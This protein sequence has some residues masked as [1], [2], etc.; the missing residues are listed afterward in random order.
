M[1]RLEGTPEFD[2]STRR[3]WTVLTIGHDRFLLT[4]AEALHL[5]D[6]LVDATER[7]TQ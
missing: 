5:A 7:T 1:I 3:R 2:V 6:L 4:D